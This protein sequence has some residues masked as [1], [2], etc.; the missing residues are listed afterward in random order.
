MQLVE[1]WFR[2]NKMVLNSKKTKFILFGVPNSCREY[3]F[4]LEIGGE[5]IDRV[6]ENN[7]EK[8]VK[9]VGVALDE[10]LSFKHH[11]H[12]MKTKL[13]RAN[14]ILARSGKFLP[15]EVRILVYNSLVKS[16]LE[17]GS[18]VYSHCGKTIIDQIFRLQKKIVRNVIGVKGRV[19]TNQF[20]IDLGLLKFRDLIDYNTKV[21]GWKI[22]NKSAPE[23][24]CEGYEET[25][26]IHNTR[27]ARDLNFKIP[28]CKK[29][30]LKF[31]PCY[32]VTKNWNEVN[33]EFKKI[34]KLGEFKAKMAYEYFENY[35]RE[36]KCKIKNC[37]ACSK[38][39]L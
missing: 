11:A 13:N 27:Y 5:R 20:F 12:H 2:A 23:N 30:T 10:K 1:R 32:S 8:Y 37:F 22:W 15:L 39:A 6:S 7:S 36:P 29:A 3:Q 9:L 21:I 17:F 31:A 38:T 16:V 18:W 25:A 14:F 26:S 35:R 24:L 34:E 4:K 33:I 28:F 19:H